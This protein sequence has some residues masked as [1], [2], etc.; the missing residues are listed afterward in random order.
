MPIQVPLP[1]LQRIQPAQKVGADRLRFKVQGQDDLIQQT[2]KN[3]AGLAGEAIELSFDIEDSK[4]EQLSNENEQEYAE[5]NAAQMQNLRSK[6]GDPTDHY[7]EYEKAE[8]KK[9]EELLSKRPDLNNR[10]QSHL[11]GNL[12]KVQS[13]QRIGVLKQK[14]LQTET[15]KN[16]L[17]E[18]T[19]KL[20]KNDLPVTAGFIQKDDPSSFVPFDQKVSDIRNTILKRGLD[21]GTVTKGKDGRI[22]VSNIA[23]A[24]VAKELSEGVSNSVKVLIDGNQSDEAR[25]VHEKYKKFIDPLSNA[26][27]EKKF[28]SNDVKE[29]AFS[30]MGELRGKTPDEQ[31][32]IID[33]IKDPE[34]FSEVLKLKEANDNRRESDRNRRSKNN[35]D[36]LANRVIAKM[37]SDEPYHGLA[38]LENDPLYKQTWD[39]I[40]DPKQKQA[41]QEL[42]EPPKQSATG[43]IARVQDILMG[44]NADLPVETITTQEFNNA[45]VGLSQKH[46]DKYNGTFERLR[47]QSAGE[48]RSTHK[49]AGNFIVNHLLKNEEIEKDKFGKFDEDDT[50]TIIEMQEAF[51]DH[52]ETQPGVFTD[53]QLKDFANEFTASKI[54]EEAPPTRPGRATTNKIEQFNLTPQDKVN[55]KFQ[56]KKQNGYLPKTNSREF[57]E[58]VRKSRQE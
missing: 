48:Q 58:F 49:R 24:R 45:L 35:Y 57:L 40:T 20:R 54:N 50:I 19:L 33:R 25:M 8:K 43:S 2:T 51:I 46:R 26:A 47:I 7:V 16:T 31:D 38:Q 14:G 6:T 39:R 56:F 15:Y 28:K 44:N 10:V 42:L 23:K 13:S 53:K 12:S 36:R 55:F 41:V 4:I 9:A 27:L 37:N 29:Q 34:V 3:V 30:F 5:W 1:K 52:L 17:F 11:E 21:T 32:A 18:S 22:T